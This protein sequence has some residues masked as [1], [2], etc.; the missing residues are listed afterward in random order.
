MPARR[1]IL[2]VVLG[3]AELALIAS[4][5]GLRPS[6]RANDLDPFLLAFAGAFALYLAA[7]ALVLR[8]ERSAPAGAASGREGRVLLVVGFALAILMRL[9]LLPARPALSDDMYRYIWDGRVQL[10]GL[11]PYRYPPAARELAALRES[12]IWRY[13]N[14]RSS[15]TIYPPAAQATFAGLAALV[16]AGRLPALLAPPGVIVFKAAFVLAELAGALLLA[17]LLAALGRSPALALVALWNPLA[18]WEI[19]HSGHLDAL[20]LPLLAGAALARVRGR[21][22]LLG[23]LLGLAGAIKFTPLLVFPALWRVRDTRGRLE[24]RAPAACAFVL[25][26]S[27]LPYLGAGTRVLGYLP[28]YVTERFNS[29]LAFGLV[30]LSE[31]AGWPPALVVNL[32]SLASLALVSALLVA[33]PA[34]DARAALARALWPLGAFLLINQNLHPW[35]T[36]WLLPFVALGLAPGRLL[37]LRAHG[38]AV[39]LLFT[40]L[41]VLAYT[42]FVRSRSDVWPQVFEFAALYGLLAIAGLSALAAR[43]RAGAARLGAAPAPAGAES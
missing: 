13:I 21:D 1:L 16:P 11:N 2:L 31:A 22:G 19:A 10:A 7:I 25:A 40:G 37:G 39:W 5:R 26:V 41:V 6:D 20:V 32:A 9:P 34:A 14:R 8:A 3:L 28:V 38:P 17:R 4:Q 12:Q 15:P 18:V 33:R 30:S 43:R 29:G 35:Y 24:W 36:L 27:Y 42:H 23:A